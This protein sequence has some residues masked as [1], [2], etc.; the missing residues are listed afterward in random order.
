MS[1]KKKLLLTNVIIFIV[2]VGLAWGYSL[3]A[4][5]LLNKF[6]ITGPSESEFD[7]VAECLTSGRS[8]AEMESFL[9]Q[10]G[11]RLSVYDTDYNLIRGDK[12]SLKSY[13]LNIHASTPTIA[14]LRQA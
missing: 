13:E 8:D 6:P 12:T 11:Y 4:N 9:L 14:A 1:I 10:S 7:T 2:M 3:F 5:A